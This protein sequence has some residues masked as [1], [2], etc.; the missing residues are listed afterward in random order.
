MKRMLKLLWK[1]TYVL[2]AVIVT[3]VASV[4]FLPS[5]GYT[6]ID[7]FISFCLIVG[8]WMWAI[9]FRYD[10]EYVR[11]HV[12]WSADAGECVT[13]S[14]LE[15]KIDTGIEIQG[16]R[17]I[18]DISQTRIEEFRLGGRWTVFHDDK[19]GVTLYRDETKIKN[20]WYYAY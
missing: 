19:S 1:E 14:I 6:M 5:L 17:I 13:T 7:R 15:K 9:L 20:C 12:E 11:C 3:V 2:S 4:T 18:I 10:W 8:T 16:N